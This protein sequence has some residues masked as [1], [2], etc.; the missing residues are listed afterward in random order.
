MRYPVRTAA[1]LLLAV[2]LAAVSCEDPQGFVEPKLTRQPIVD[3]YNFDMEGQ[4]QE[5]YR[6]TV[7][8]EP[9]MVHPHLEGKWTFADNER[10]IDIYVVPAASYDPNRLPGEQEVIR[11]S[12]LQDAIVGQQRQTSMRIHPEPGEWVIILYNGLPFAATS[13]ARVSSEI[14]LTYFE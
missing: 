9:D 14:D 7:L 6:V 2:S 1:G 5:V 4:Q 3:L 11:W 13:R 8:P 10:P 12:S